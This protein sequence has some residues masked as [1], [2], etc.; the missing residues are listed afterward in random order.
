MNLF[1]SLAGKKKPFLE[2]WFAKIVGTYPG[3][4]AVFLHKKNPIGNP[5]GVN[6]R[7]AL[8]DLFDELVAG[9]PGERARAHVETIVRIRAVQEFTPGQ[10]V[11]VMFLAK[12]A[13][14]ETLGQEA[15]ADFDCFLELD[16]RIDKLALVAFDVHSRIREQIYELRIADARQRYSG[17]LR[18]LGMISDTPGGDPGEDM[19]GGGPDNGEPSSQ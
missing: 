9:E 10:V 11:S 7:G 17:I 1:D 18:R 16:A 14:I 8:E 3:L 19:A 12:Q 2:N 15:A 6:I 4:S 5:V 13:A